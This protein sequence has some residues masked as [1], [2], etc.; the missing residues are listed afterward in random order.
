MSVDIKKFDSIIKALGIDKAVVKEIVAGI[1]DFSK[2]LTRLEENQRKIVETLGALTT[3]A[4]ATPA[5]EPE[6]KSSP[7]P[8]VGEFLAQ[9]LRE[10]M[11][12]SDPMYNEMRKL[13]LENMKLSTR[14]MRIRLRREELLSKAFESGLAKRLGKEA[15]KG[16]GLHE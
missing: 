9:V 13:T 14:L 11:T 16:L 2:R 12:P 1:D 7:S 5:P 10:V 3:M 8:A 6:G 4:S 15:L